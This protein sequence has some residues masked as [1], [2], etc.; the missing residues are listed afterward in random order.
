VGLGRS[1]WRLWSASVVSNLGD[2]VSSLAYPWLAGALTRNPVAIAAVTLATR[3]PWLLVS[4]P[5]GR[6]STGSTRSVSWS[7]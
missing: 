5:P 2:G 4:L 3:L 7:P 6:S 1:Y